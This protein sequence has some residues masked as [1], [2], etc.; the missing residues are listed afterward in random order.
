MKNQKLF[1]GTLLISTGVFFLLDSFQLPLSESLL[2]WPII[3]LVLGLAFLVQGTIGKEQHALF[4]GII[5]FGL[6]FHFF[7]STYFSEWPTS[8]GI[9]TLIIGLAFLTQKKTGSKTALLLI[10]ISL[11]E[12]FYPDFQQWQAKLLG[13]LNGFWPLLLIGLGAYFIFK[14]K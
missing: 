2:N 4:P 13:L 8:W 10:G 14:K 5:L 12:L 9:Y 11:L 7:A 3:L 6:G 1:I